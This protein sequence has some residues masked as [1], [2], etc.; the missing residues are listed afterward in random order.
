VERT[1][2]PL[3]KMKEVVKEFGEQRAVDG[4]TINFHGGEIFCLLGHNGAG[5]STTINL[6][7]GLLRP[8]S[9]KIDVLGLK[10]P[11]DVDQ[12]RQNIGLC[13][14]FNVLYDMLTV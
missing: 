11:G 13:L 12:I 9:G 7:T 10:Y 8:N 1:D 3:I 6:L 5:K 2:E 4:L 14:Q